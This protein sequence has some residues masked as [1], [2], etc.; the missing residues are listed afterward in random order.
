MLLIAL[1]S[2][3]VAEDAAPGQAG[4]GQP[5]AWRRS[6]RN[7]LNLKAPTTGRRQFAARCLLLALSTIACYH[8]GAGAALLIKAAPLTALILIG[9]LLHCF[10]MT[11]TD[12]DR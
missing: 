2:F 3:F 11:W 6:V 10:A 12:N 1:S 5:S 8:L 7:V 9:A 4:D